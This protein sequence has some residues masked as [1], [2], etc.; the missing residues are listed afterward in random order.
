VSLTLAAAFT[1]VLILIEHIAL[2]SAPWRLEP[3]ASYIVGTATIG[4]GVLLY[5]AQEHRWEAALVF[6]CVAGAAGATDVAA[7]WVRARLALRDAVSFQAG[8]VAGLEEE[9]RGAADKSA[10][11][12]D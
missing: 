12:G 3:P 8:Q 4:L 2:W 11:S 5:C 9:D 7:Y 6:W 10:I 1:A